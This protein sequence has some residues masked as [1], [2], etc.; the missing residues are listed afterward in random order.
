VFLIGSRSAI[1]TV[2]ADW[3]ADALALALKK[4]LAEGTPFARQK[5]VKCGAVADLNCRRW[6]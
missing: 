4:K 6:H 5:N 3:I 2:R 1:E